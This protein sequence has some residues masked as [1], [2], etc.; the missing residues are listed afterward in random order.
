MWN[1][2]NDKITSQAMLFDNVASLW[3]QV[4]ESANEI[5]KWLDDIDEIIVESTENKKEAVSCG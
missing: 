4:E 2:S 1:R 5:N 3:S